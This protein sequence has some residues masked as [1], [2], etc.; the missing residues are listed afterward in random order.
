[1]KDGIRKE[2]ILKRKHIINKEEKSLIIQ[3][4]VLEMDVFQSAKVVALYKSMKDEV[5]TSLLIDTCLKM[6]KIVCLPKV[7]GNHLC[8]YQIGSDEKYVKSIFQVEEPLGEDKYLL[9]S[10]DIDVIVVPGVVFDNLGHRM[11]FGRGYYDRYLEG[12]TMYKI[13]VCFR[14]QIVNHVIVDLHDVDMDIV[15]TD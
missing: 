13:G 6:G 11:G 5:D 4:K 10:K 14:E 8:F 15:V 2:Y 9:D 1:M 12:N 7:D 3:H